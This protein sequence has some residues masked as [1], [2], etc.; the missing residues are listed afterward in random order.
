M[1]ARITCTVI[2]LFY[3]LQIVMQLPE[4][5]RTVFLYIC[6]FLQEL[7]NHTQDNELDAKTLGKIL[8]IINLCHYAQSLLIHYSFCSNAVWIDFLKRSTEE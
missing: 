5:R 7:L 8:F 1:E 6:Y 3:L 2:T 4:I